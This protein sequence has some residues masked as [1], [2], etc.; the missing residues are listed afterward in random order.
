MIDQIKVTDSIYYVGVN[1]RT[2]P[3]F[4]GLWPIPHGVAYNSYLIV[5]EKITLIDTVDLCYSEQFFH[6]IEQIIGDKPIDYLIVD[7]MEPDHSGSLGMRPRALS[8]YHNRRQQGD[9][10][11]HE[12]VLSTP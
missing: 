5:D 11:N 1:D 6:Q 4:E 2:K 3:L 9:F 8:R 7:H 12:G 10:Q